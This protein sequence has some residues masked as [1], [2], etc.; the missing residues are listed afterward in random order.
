MSNIHV[1]SNIN[2]HT[3]KLKC[4]KCVVTRITPVQ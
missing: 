3:L 4:V 2:K 1:I